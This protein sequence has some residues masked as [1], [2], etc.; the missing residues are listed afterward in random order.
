MLKSA[1]SYS[2]GLL[3]EAFSFSDA[4]FERPLRATLHR[5]VGIMPATQSAGIKGGLPDEVGNYCVHG[6]LGEGTFG[7]V[8]KAQHKLAGERVAIKVLEKR[9]MQQ[10]DDVRKIV[11]SRPF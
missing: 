1:N 6:K 10:A 7:V 5:L 8:L 11:E 4:A 9:R 3:V 2:C